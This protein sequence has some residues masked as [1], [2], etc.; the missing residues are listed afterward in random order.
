[1]AGDRTALEHLYNVSYSSHGDD[2]TLTLTP[3]DSRTSQAIHAIT[4]DGTRETLHTV[5]V[6]QA[7]G[8][9]S[10]MQLGNPSSD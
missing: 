5:V 9:H 7:D 3:L 10:V 1:M 6:Q 2:W 4:L 8:D